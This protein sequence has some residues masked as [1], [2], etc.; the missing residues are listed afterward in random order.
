MDCVWRNDS[1]LYN[2]FLSSEVL[3]VMCK[4]KAK[5]CTFQILLV[6][7][8]LIAQTQILLFF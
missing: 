8:I 6:K 1:Y 4:E 5:I 7:N 3:N 2:N